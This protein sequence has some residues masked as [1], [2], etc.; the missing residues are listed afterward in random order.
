MTKVCG[1]FAMD[2]M[3]DALGDAEA[4]VCGTEYEIES[5]K[6]IKLPGHSV[7][8][9][10]QLN[11]NEN[12][13]YWVGD[14]GLVHDGS[15]RNGGVEFITK[16][17]SFDR[18][19]ALFDTLHKGLT[20]GEN[21]Y[22]SRTSI[23]VHVNMASLSMDQLKHFLLTYA[24]L[25]PVFFEVAGDTRKPAWGGTL[26]ASSL[27]S[28]KRMKKPLALLCGHEQP[29]GA[30]NSP[31]AHAQADCSARKLSRNFHNL[32]S[33]CATWIGELH[34]VIGLPVRRAI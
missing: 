30:S 31:S 32:K 6:T 3:Y 8:V 9:R 13:P 29:P 1:F 11:L 21:P 16:P 33:N 10:D 20:L 18:A 5:V 17:V 27:Q 14:I 34:S 23:H 2:L 19:L 4:F 15:L 28:V 7:M 24:L 25:E 26:I 12:Q 22:T